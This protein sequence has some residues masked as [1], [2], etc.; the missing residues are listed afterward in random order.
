M[1]KITLLLF[2]TFCFTLNAQVLTEDFEA[3]GVPAG[4]TSTPTSGATNWTSAAANNSGNVTP[5]TGTGMGFYYSGNYNGDMATLESPA[6]DLSAVA[7]Q[8]LTFY[9]TQEDWG[10]DQDELRVYYKTSAAGALVELAA[11]TTSV[12][13]WTEVNLVLPNPSADYYVVFEATSGYG[14]GVGIDDLVIDDAPSCLT[15]GS[16]SVFA[17]STTTADLS[18]IPGGTETDFTFEF[19]APGFTQGTG[20]I[21]TVTGT[22]GSISGLTA[23]NSYDFYV[24]ANCAGGDSSPAGPFNWLQP[25]SGDSC[26]TAY[27]A[28]L[29]ADCGTATPTT[30]DFTGAPS[31]VSTSCDTFNNYGLWITTTT[32][33]AGGLTV[34]ASGTLGGMAI[35]DACGGTEVFCDGGDISPSTDVVLSPSTQY[36]LFFWQEGTAS[37]A[38]VDI[39]LSSYTPAPAPDCADGVNFPADDATDI[40]AFGTI[41]LDWDAP[42]GGETPTAYNIYSGTTSGAL[43]LLATVDAPATT[44]DTTVGAYSTEIFW[45]VVPVNG[46]TEAVGPCAEWSFTSADAPPPPGNDLCDNAT[47]ITCGAT[48]TAQS[49]VNATGGSA[50]SCDGTIGDDVWYQFTGND[51]DVTITVNASVEEAQIGVFE[52]A[53]CA[54]ITDLAACFAS[55][56]GS[57]SNPVEV[58]FA[59]AAGNEY[60]IQVGNWINGD[61]GLTF[62]ISATCTPFPTCG[63]PSN[64]DA[65]P[66]DVT[67]DLSWDAAV[68]GTPIGYNWEIQPDGVAQG[69]ATP[70]TGNTV[71]LTDTATGL[72]AETAYDLYVQTDCDAD[73]TSL[74]TG[75][76]SFT[77]TIAPPACGGN[78]YDTGGNAGV[79]SANENYTITICPDTP[80]DAVSVAFTSFL[81]EGNGDG[82]C[83]DELLIFDGADNTGTPITPVSLGLNPAAATDGFCWQ[84]AGDG[85]ADL[86]GQTIVSSDASGCLTFTFTSDGS[87]QFDGWEATVGCAPLSSADIDRANAFTYYPN[88]VKSTLSLTARNNDIQNVAVYNMLGQEVLRTSPNSLHTNVDTSALQTGAYFVK[89][90]INNV[91][92]TI[93]V[94]KQ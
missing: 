83:W 8:Q 41:T 51:M 79:H 57:G 3:A 9:Y 4:W 25:D 86:T 15:P 54:G 40:D 84:A 94:I 49:T 18:W 10:G 77:T 78:F 44:Y 61:P 76:F 64:L 35:Y 85:T 30:L 93:R 66:T 42:S 72:T 13:T 80:G 39:C 21:D 38:M 73:G 19:G 1:K 82:D 29:E 12:S 7:S 48:L 87:G 89:V 37:T 55:A 26:G 43:T 47:P 33:A 65:S 32:D 31:N 20:T 59:A 46:A 28:A 11:Y 45:S 92:E 24:T 67:A 27:V 91:T 6:M 68:I 34:N 53:D 36:Y 52:S 88:P 70:F 74:W 5:R 71:G 16:L 23:G 2:L 58:T 14:Y 69:T 56:A 75:P 63:E 62:E 17:T 90:T 22:T 60:F 50:T 81:V